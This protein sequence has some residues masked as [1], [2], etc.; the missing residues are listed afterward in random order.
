MKNDPENVFAAAWFQ[1]KKRPGQ[2][3]VRVP[4]VRFSL[5]AWYIFPF[6]T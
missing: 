2:T 5:Y 4:P 1:G 3:T 6:Q